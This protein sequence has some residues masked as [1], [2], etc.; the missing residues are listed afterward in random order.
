MKYVD[1]TDNSECAVFLSINFKKD[2]HE[3]AISCP[4]P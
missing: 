3:A 4:G 1:N 2:K